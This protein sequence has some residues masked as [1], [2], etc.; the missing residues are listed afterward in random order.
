MLGIPTHPLVVHFPIVLV[1]LLPII[2]LVA[3]WTIRRGTDSRRAWIAPTITALALALS[4][5]LALETGEAQED[6]VERVVP[7]SAIHD[8]AE[9]AERFLALS[10]VVFAVTGAGLVSGTIGRAARLVATVGAV[11]LVGAGIQVGHSGG[12]LVYR[13]GAASAYTNSIPAGGSDR[14]RG[15]GDEH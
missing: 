15:E 2:A 14:I 7:E 6:V 8:H 9:A 4:A 5:W 10:V 13:H 11:G 12:S 3:I 1:V